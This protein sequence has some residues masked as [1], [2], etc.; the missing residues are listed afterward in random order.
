[1]PH[2]S[3]LKHNSNRLTG[4]HKVRYS[5]G[6]IEIPTK[7]ILFI[8]L[9]ALHVSGYAH[10]QELQMYFAT[11]GV[12][13]LELHLPN[14][15]TSLKNAAQFRHYL[16]FATETTHMAV[17]NTTPPATR[18]ATHDPTRLQ[19]PFTHHTS[20]QRLDTP[21]AAPRRSMLLCN[22]LHNNIAGCPQT[23]QYFCAII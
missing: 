22:I 9:S 13:T 20:S 5:K 12:C 3:I 1:M 4:L 11:I 14:L 21:K 19:V 17:P 10:L 2:Y 18:H 23:V 6:F 7:C 15:N 16:S 8:Y